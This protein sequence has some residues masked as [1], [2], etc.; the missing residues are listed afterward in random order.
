MVLCEI[1]VD[2]NAPKL[3]SHH[4]LSHSEKISVSQQSLRQVHFAVIDAVVQLDAQL[5][6]QIIMAI[7]ETAPDSCQLCIMVSLEKVLTACSSKPFPF[8]LRNPEGR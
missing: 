1:A 8:A 6:R 4:A 2:V 3:T 5:P 7:D